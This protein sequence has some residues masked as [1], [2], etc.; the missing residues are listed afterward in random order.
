MKLPELQ[1]RIAQ[2]AKAVIAGDATAVEAFVAPQGLATWR[3]AAASID[4]GRPLDSFEL[5]ACAKIGMQFMAKTRFRGAKG[6]ALLLIRWK[7]SDGKW[8]IAEAEDITGKRSP[9]SDIPHY[10]AERRGA[11]NA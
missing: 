4:G 5:L 7:Q 3:A 6:A 1:E 11:S 9:W 10:T 2:H 8:I